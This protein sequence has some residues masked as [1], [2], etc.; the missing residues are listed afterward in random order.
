M[1]QFVSFNTALAVLLAFGMGSSLVAPKLGAED[2]TSS[3]SFVEQL[4]IKSIPRPSGVSDRLDAKTIDYVF[5]GIPSTRMDMVHPS[6][7]FSNMVFPEWNLKPAG[8]ATH[9][10]AFIHRTFQDTSLSITLFKKGSYIDATDTDSLLGVAADLYQKYGDSITFEPWQ[11]GEF[12]DPNMPDGLVPYLAK[13]IGYTVSRDGLV[14]VVRLYYF[15]IGSWTVEVAF[16]GNESSFGATYPSFDEYI[17][18]LVITE[19]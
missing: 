4:S 2:E 9:S 3:K 6:I 5:D 8:Y 18:R 19:Q 16:E 10:I 1:N 13:A 12:N 17:N 14:K 11:N 7:V 15:P